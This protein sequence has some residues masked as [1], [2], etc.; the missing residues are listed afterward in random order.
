M[1]LVLLYYIAR[2]LLLFLFFPSKIGSG[3][4]ASAELIERDRD[5]PRW[6]SLGWSLSDWGAPHPSDL[7]LAFRRPFA[8]ILCDSPHENGKWL[9]E[10][11][12]PIKLPGWL[13]SGAV[14]A[15]PFQAIACMWGVPRRKRD[16]EL[17]ANAR[18][19]LAL[20][21]LRWFLV[22]WPGT[23]LGLGRVCQDVFLQSKLEWERH[24]GMCQF[25]CHFLFLS[26]APANLCCYET[27]A[28][29][30]QTIL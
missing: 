29:W 19:V 17:A 25:N 24:A 10:Q 16:A 28:V 6:R 11:R 22:L 23:R 21:A 20:S 4:C 15:P 12:M 5:R 8:Q 13:I 27:H 7:Q 3:C 1:C 14:F 30:C 9:T 18:S 26:M 2:H